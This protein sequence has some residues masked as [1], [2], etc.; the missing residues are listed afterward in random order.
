MI[1]K[2]V[3]IAIIAAAIVFAVF[4]KIYK[5]YKKNKNLC[6]TDCCHCSTSSTCSP[7]KENHTK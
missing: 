1:I 3:I 7:H 6:G 5:D 2:T 4:R